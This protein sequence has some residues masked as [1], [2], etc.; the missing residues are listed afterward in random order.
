MIP[1]KC[2]YK[3]KNKTKIIKVGNTDTLGI[4]IELTEK[5]R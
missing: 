5:Q 4:I 3:N 2:L 1:Q